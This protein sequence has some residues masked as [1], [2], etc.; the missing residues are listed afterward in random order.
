MKAL[1]IWQIHC[2]TQIECDL[3]AAGWRYCGLSDRLLTL[4]CEPIFDRIGTCQANIPQQLFSSNTVYCLLV[5][6][7]AHVIVGMAAAQKKKKKKTS[8][9]GAGHT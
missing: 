3:T 6:A 4:V 7:L 2:R 8:D 1:F 9:P 5:V